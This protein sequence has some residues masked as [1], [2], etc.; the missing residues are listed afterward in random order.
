[1][2][3]EKLDKT[4]KELDKSSKQLKGFSELFSELSSLHNSIKKNNDFFKTATTKIEN[5]SNSIDNSLTDFQKTFIELDSSL[6]SRLDRHKSDIQVV[7][8]NEGTQI[9]R[10]FENSLNSNFN[11]LENKVNEKFREFETKIKSNKTLIIISLISGLIN[12]G[13]IA[14][15]IFGQ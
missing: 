3:L 8:R 14:F 10:G 7:I 9:Q 5:V 12:I 11:S 2:D 1:M 4:I 15:L 13:M 6:V